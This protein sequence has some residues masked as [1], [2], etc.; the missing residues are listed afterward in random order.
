MSLLFPLN[1][2]ISHQ[3]GFLRGHSFDEISMVHTF[4]FLSFGTVVVCE[5]KGS[6]RLTTTD[7]ERWGEEAKYEQLC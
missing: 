1:V 6:G 5:V 4:L 7:G 3:R 2:K